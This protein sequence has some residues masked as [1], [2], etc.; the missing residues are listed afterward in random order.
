MDWIL[1]PIFRNGELLEKS[2]F[3]VPSAV[4]DLGVAEKSRLKPTEPA[5][6]GRGMS[7]VLQQIVLQKVHYMKLHLTP[8]VFSFSLSV[9]QREISWA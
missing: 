2:P 6:G 5:V 9:T 3:T 1:F 7:V 4:L 8:N